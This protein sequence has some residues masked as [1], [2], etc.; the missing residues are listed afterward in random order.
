M[1][2][3]SDHPIQSIFTERWSP[4]AFDPEKSISSED[5]TCM[6]EAARWTMSAKN[7]QPWRYIVGVKGAGDGVWEKLLEGFMPGNQPWAQYAPV[8]AVTLVSSCFDD[9]MPNKCAQYDLGAASA[10]LTSEATAR[11]IQIHQCGGIDPEKIKATFEL[12]GSFEPLTGIVMGYAGSAERIDAM[13]A[14]RETKPRVRLSLDELIVHGG[15]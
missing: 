1:K 11:G 15:C 9:G 7:S 4:Y 10:N 8:L 12:D 13:Y 14:D 3:P 5:L 2:N 6:F